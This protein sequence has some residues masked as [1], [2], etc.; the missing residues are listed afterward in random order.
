[1]YNWRLGI[2]KK[3]PYSNKLCF[4]TA[5]SSILRRAISFDDTTAGKTQVRAVENEAFQQIPMSMI[6][7]S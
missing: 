3:Y 5:P 2:F 1:M 6:N 4:C 7:M